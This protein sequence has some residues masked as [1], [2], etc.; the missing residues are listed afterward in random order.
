M[1]IKIKLN[2]EPV[3]IKD[4]VA[5]SK[6]KPIEEL[7]NFVSKTIGLGG[8]SYMGYLP[9]LRDIFGDKIRVIDVEDEPKDVIH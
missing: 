9:T 6:N 4:G 5:Y 8:P 7:I 3:T 2:G 1:I